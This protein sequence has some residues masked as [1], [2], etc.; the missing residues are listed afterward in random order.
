M[1]IKVKVN[2]ETKIH[3]INGKQNKSK[4]GSQIKK[5]SLTQIIYGKETKIVSSSVRMT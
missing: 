2:M 4:S 1:K 3:D 5:G